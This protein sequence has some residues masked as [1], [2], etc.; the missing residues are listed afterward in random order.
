MAYIAGTSNVILGITD[1]LVLDPAHR[2]LITPLAE[3]GRWG[4][5]MDL[6]ATGSAITWLAGLLGGDLTA[7][8]LIELA[9]STEQQT[10]P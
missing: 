4:V 7:A 10:P 8:G 9:A 1:R 6:L 5:E 3:S 2:F